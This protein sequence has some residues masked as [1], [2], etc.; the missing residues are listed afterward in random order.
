MTHKAMEDLCIE[1]LKVCINT[2]LKEIKEI[3][4]TWD[5]YKLSM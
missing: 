4:E 2:G 5:D 1:T 3:K